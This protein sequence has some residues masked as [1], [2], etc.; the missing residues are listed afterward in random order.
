MTLEER[1]IADGIHSIIHYAY[2]KNGWRIQ[3]TEEIQGNGSV[4]TAVTSYRYDANGNLIKIT[5]PKG[6]EIAYSFAYQYD[7]NGNRTEKE[8]IQ[9]KAALGGNSAL[10]ISYSYD[11]REQFLEERWNGATV[12]YA[13]EKAGNRIRKTDTQGELCYFYNEKNQHIMEESINGRKQFTYNRQG[14]ILE[15][16]RS[17]GI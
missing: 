2:N 10:D 8:G 17:T 1:V 13:Y 4:Q 3:K 14:G 9:A 7:S 12:R 11:V 15:E 5:T 6:V 16:K